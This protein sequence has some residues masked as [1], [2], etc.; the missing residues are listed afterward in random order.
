MKRT[1]LG[2]MFALALVPA[3]AA[4]GSVGIGVFGGASLPILYDNASIGGQAGLRVPVNVLPMLTIEPY[5]AQSRLG[6]HEDTFAGQTYTRSG[7]ELYTYGGNA[8]FEFG[9]GVKFYPFVGIGSTRIEQESAEDV[10]DTNLNFGLGF[11]FSAMAKLALD[12]RG[13]LQAVITG[14]T[15]RKFGNITLGVSYA[16]FEY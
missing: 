10:T 11:K 12:L 6:D 16:L 1:L 4:A 3:V 9:E 15:S 14:D 13:E 2:A 8:V 5:Y 7:P